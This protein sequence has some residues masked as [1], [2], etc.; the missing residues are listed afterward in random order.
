MAE[1]DNTD[2]I[3]RE[4]FRLLPNKPLDIFIDDRP[5]TC[6]VP[7]WAEVRAKVASTLSRPRPGV[8]PNALAVVLDDWPPGVVAEVGNR[9]NPKRLV[10]TF[11]RCRAGL[12]VLPTDP[13]EASTV[14]DTFERELQDAFLDC[15]DS[16]TQMMLFAGPS[17]SDRSTSEAEHTPTPEERRK[18]ILHFLASINVR[19]P[20]EME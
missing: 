19:L 2:K 18:A 9:Q 7:T 4:L 11:E 12:R 1:A 15:G 13:D 10:E 3:W 14:I 20:A 6:V 16:T 17:K 5:P 8:L